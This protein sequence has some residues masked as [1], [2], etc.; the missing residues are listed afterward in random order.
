MKAITWKIKGSNDVVHL[1]K[2]ESPTP[3]YITGPVSQINKLST[4]FNK[5][6]ISHEIEEEAISIDGNV[7]I[8]LINFALRT[9]MDVIFDVLCDVG[10]LFTLQDLPKATISGS[11]IANKRFQIVNRAVE[12]IIAQ[13]KERNIDI[14]EHHLE[15]SVR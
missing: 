4:L 8:T 6:N 11:H 5:Y 9:N 1:C 15:I 2:E 3:S 10:E 7:E 14:S 13:C 12:L